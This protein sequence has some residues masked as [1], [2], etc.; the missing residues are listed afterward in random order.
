LTPVEG[1]A[2]E[3]RFDEPQLAVTP[4]QLAVF[5]LGDRCIGGA[6]ISCSLQ[7]SGLRVGDASA[8]PTHA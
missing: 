3:V 1:G 8:A 2:L 7:A 6:E 5:Y 4:G